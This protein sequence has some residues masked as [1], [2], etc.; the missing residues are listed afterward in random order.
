MSWV[1]DRALTLVLMAMFFGFL[2]G[3]LLTGKAEQNAVAH[4]QPRPALVD[5]LDSS[6]F[7]FQS[8]QNWQS[9][10]LAIASMV[11]LGVYLR[12]RRSPVSKPVRVPRRNRSV[13]GSEHTTEDRKT[14]EETEHSRETANSQ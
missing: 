5:Y 6:Q 1:R 11:W 9:E 13:N 7:W 10:F 12:Q 3:Q 8:F 4:H 2:I 14:P